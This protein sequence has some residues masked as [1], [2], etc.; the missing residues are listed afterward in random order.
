MNEQIKQAISAGVKILQ[1][2]TTP[3]PGNLKV[4]AV[5]LEQLLRSILAGQVVLADAPKKP[6]QSPEG[7]VNQGAYSESDRGNQESDSR[8]G[9]AETQTVPI[10][11][12]GQDAQAKDV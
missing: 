11:E 7:T 4:Q 12:E 8:R 10:R 1:M 5:V 2:E 3:I 9:K 6:V